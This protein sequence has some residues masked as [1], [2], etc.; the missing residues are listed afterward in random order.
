VWR[1]EL[2]MDVVVFAVEQQWM[3]GRRSA[4]VGRRRTTKAN[5][6]W[7]EEQVVVVLGAFHRR[8]PSHPR[9]PR[10]AIVSKTDYYV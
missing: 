9:P 6:K 10:S 1:T 7:R 3:E 4:E 8:Q 5:E 2:V